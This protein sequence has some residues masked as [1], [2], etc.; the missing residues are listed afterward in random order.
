MKSR[1]I[2]DKRG[3]CFNRAIGV[4]E[5]NKIFYAQ[6]VTMGTTDPVCS[7]SFRLKT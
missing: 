2:W 3:H 1:D 6:W 5:G 7:L 4:A